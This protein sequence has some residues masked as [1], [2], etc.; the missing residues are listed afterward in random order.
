VKK[1]ELSKRVKFLEGEID[2]LLDY[3]R[4]KERQI[5]TQQQNI[6]HLER[7]LDRANNALDRA[8]AE[9]KRLKGKKS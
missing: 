6:E 4:Q 1:A 2:R 9:L 5:Q 7:E 8:E 3:I